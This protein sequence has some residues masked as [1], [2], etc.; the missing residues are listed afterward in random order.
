[1]QVMNARDAV[2]EIKSILGIDTTMSTTTIHFEDGQ[3][4]RL[5]FLFEYIDTGYA[6]LPHGFKPG[7]Q[8][9]GSYVV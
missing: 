5:Q 7:L 4:E 2:D 1:M 8:A 3:Y 9:D 6:A